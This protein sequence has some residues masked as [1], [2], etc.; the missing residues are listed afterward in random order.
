MSTT[1]FEF[2]HFYSHCRGQRHNL[3]SHMAD[4]VVVE[5]SAEEAFF[6]GMPGLLQHL[7]A[8]DSRSDSV[9]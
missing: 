7:I 4:Q 9:S 1:V 5:G 8:I 3:V 6:P 2:S